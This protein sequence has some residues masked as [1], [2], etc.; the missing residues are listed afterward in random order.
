MTYLYD[1]HDYRHMIDYATIN[2]DEEVAHY[3]NINKVKII[4]LFCARSVW[5][6]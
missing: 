2:D 4:F 1:R 3:R 6:M 5:F